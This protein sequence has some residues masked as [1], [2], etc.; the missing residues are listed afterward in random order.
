MEYYDEL[1]VNILS[2]LDEPDKFLGKLR[3][4]LT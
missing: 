2:N 4:K 3:L 1:Y